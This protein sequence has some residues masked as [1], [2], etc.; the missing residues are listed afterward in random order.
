MAP[1]P[2]LFCLLAILCAF[3]AALLATIAA[4]RG[5]GGAGSRDVA[6]FCGLILACG[7]VCLVAARVAS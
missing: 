2:A 7:V 1:L 5:S 4:G 6:A 3:D